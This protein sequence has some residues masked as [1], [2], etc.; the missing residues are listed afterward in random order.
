LSQLA[1]YER[2]FSVSVPEPVTNVGVSFFKITFNYSKPKN[3]PIKE[4]E[5]E[6]EEGGEESVRDFQAKGM[7]IYKMIIFFLP[8]TY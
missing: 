6:E 4:E 7:R 2:A 8:K 1:T 5:E 3:N